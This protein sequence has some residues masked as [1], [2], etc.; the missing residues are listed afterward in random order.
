MSGASASLKRTSTVFLGDQS[1]GKTSVITRFVYDTF[2]TTYH[3]TTVVEC[4]NKNIDLDDRTVPLKLQDTSGQERFHP[5]TST[6]IRDSSV[7]VVVYD[8]TDRASYMS[9]N[10]WISQARSEMGPD[11]MI[12][13]IGNKAD[14]SDNRQVPFEEA[15]QR[16]NELDIIF[17]ETSAKA[18]QTVQAV[19]KKIAICLPCTQ[20]LSAAGDQLRSALDRYGR[21]CSSARNACLGGGRLNGAT[22]IL[23]SLKKES[24]DITSHIQRLE[25]ARAAIHAARSSIPKVV[26]ITAL[27]AEIVTHAGDDND[28]DSDEEVEIALE[29]LRRFRQ[30]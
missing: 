5:L 17:M 9:I 28:D 27:P 13:L 20:E 3:A 21:A 23:A 14:L 30:W 25:D 18:G 24:S 12:V 16:A 26:P 7:A 29:H 6:Y 10:K 2:D 19:F 4:V 8:I 22:E 1:V 15:T 11:V